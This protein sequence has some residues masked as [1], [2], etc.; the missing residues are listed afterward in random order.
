MT[1]DPQDLY[2]TCNSQS[3]LRDSHSFYWRLNNN[4]CIEM[5]LMIS[6]KHRGVSGQQVKTYENPIIQT[7]GRWIP[8]AFIAP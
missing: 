2:N 1:A 4:C 8:T 5:S 6:N 7:V 3:P